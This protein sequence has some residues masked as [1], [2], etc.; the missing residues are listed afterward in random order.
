MHRI[1]TKQDVITDENDEMKSSREKK[2][3]KCKEMANWRGSNKFVYLLKKSNL[4]KK[5]KKM[6]VNL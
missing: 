2:K 5:L 1:C 3:N 6:Y 4:R